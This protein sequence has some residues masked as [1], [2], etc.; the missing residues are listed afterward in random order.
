[1]Q[2]AA[3]AAA[4]VMP[5]L[6]RPPLTA[7]NASTASATPGKPGQRKHFLPERVVDRHGKSPIAVHL[8][9]FSQKVWPVIRPP[10]EHVE[11]PLV[12][13]FMC[14][15]A[16]EF[17]YAVRR[18]CEQGCQQGEGEANLAAFGGCARTPCRPWTGPAH[19]HTGGSSQPPAPHDPDRLK[20]TAKIS[21]VQVAP[22]RRDV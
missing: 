13:H 5:R 9:H 16:D 10:L 17:L 20:R 2:R 8:R 11:L 12:D 15:G 7:V 18:A 1:M 3:T 6:D 19:E 14:E 21:I 4:M 22:D